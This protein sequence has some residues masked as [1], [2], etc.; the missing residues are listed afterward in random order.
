[1][2][3]IKPDS[4]RGKT[5]RLLSA[6][7]EPLLVK[8]IVEKVEARASNIGKILIQFEEEGIAKRSKSIA[9]TVWAINPKIDIEELFTNP[10]KKREKIKQTELHQKNKKATPFGWLIDRS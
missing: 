10:R 6:A 2:H 8:Q 4:Q 3:I 1:M 5:I 9:G 7:K